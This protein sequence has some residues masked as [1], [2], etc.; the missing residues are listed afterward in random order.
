MEPFQGGGQGG[1][2]LDVD[3]GTKEVEEL[4]EEVGHE[5]LLA[6]ASDPAL[7][8]ALPQSG[9]GTRRGDDSNGPSIV[10]ERLEPEIPV[11]G[12]HDLVQEQNRRVVI[13]P[14]AA[15]EDGAHQAAEVL[16]KQQ[17]VIEP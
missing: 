3:F 2:D 11:A 6:P 16:P 17:R 10:V 4:G 15:L 9:R 14:A 5:V 1:S 8:P 7:E 13:G 12:V